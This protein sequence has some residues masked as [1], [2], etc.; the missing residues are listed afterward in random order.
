MQVFEIEEDYESALETNVTNETYA[1]ENQPRSSDAPLSGGSPLKI[2]TRG[3]LNSVLNR[4]TDGFVAS[5]LAQV[6]NPLPVG[7]DASDSKTGPQGIS[8]GPATRRRMTSIQPHQSSLLDHGKIHSNQ[9]KAFP[10]ISDN[11]TPH[12]E[13]TRDAS[14]KSKELSVKATRVETDE[15]QDDA[16]DIGMQM[17]MM[18]RLDEIEQRQERIEDLLFRISQC[19]GVTEDH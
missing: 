16:D 7:D 8:F 1:V 14:H 2:I 17:T 5:P 12:Q 19:I 3:R 11:N 15:F 9:M 18:K 6:F 10:T 4:P 13:K